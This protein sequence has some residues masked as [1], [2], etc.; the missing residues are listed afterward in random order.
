ML[1]EL[2]TEIDLHYEDE[3]FFALAKTFRRMKKA[4]AL[5]ELHGIKVPRTVHEVCNR[6]NRNYQ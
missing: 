6:F 1:Y 5:L 2:A 4:I 3:D